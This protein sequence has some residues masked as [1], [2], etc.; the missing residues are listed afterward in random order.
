MTIS[1]STTPDSTEASIS[2]DT[3]NYDCEEQNDSLTFDPLKR[4]RNDIV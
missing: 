1:C 4:I 3:Q 2:L